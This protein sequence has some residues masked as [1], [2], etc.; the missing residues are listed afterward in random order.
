[1][2]ENIEDTAEC[3]FNLRLNNGWLGVQSV[4]EISDSALIGSRTRFVDYVFNQLYKV[5]NVENKNEKDGV[6]K[7]SV[8]PNISIIK[9]IKSTANEI[10]NY[11]RGENEHRMCDHQSHSILIDGECPGYRYVSNFM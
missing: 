8:L 9:D 4:V 11:L 2:S 5:M 10:K 1:M 3:I 6:L 7:L